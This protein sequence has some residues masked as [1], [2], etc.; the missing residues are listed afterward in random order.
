M[1]SAQIYS[2]ALLQLER[3]N[4]LLIVCQRR[5]LIYSIL[6]A[7]TAAG[8][9]G[10]EHNHS[11]SREIPK[12]SWRCHAHVDVILLHHSFKNIVVF[13]LGG[14]DRGEETKKKGNVE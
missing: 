7:V 14:A 4:R 1:A 2:I 9:T 11:M 12:Q 10:V 13:L 5:N 3:A 8:P 6:R